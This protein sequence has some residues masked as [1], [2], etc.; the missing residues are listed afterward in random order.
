MK[1]KSALVTAASGSVNGLVASHNRGGQYLRGKTIPTNPSSSFQVAVRD[2]MALLTSAW[3]QTLTAL[4]RQGWQDYADAV[5]VTDALGEKRKLT[6]LNWYIAC[7]TPRFLASLARVD[8]PPTV[9]TLAALTNPGITSFTA[10]TRVLVATYTNTDGWAI[11]TGGALLFFI[12]RPQSPGVNYFKGPYR[13]LGSVAG[14]T[15]TPPTSPFTSGAGPFSTG[16]GNNV[17]IQARALNADG[18]ISSPFRASK[19]AV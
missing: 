15:A 16:V 2:Q 10:S 18:R 4:Q 1:Y 7:N 3:S 12:S 13:F 9:F 14:N 5:E 6:G 17:F 8:A 11:T 19:L